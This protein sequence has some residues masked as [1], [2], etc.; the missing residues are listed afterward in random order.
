MPFVA[1][2]QQFAG[3]VGVHLGFSQA[4]KGE[5]RVDERIEDI[6]Q[7]P[8]PVGQ[9]GSGLAERIVLGV[10]GEC[11]VVLV[12]VQGGKEEGVKQADDQPPA[13]A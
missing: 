1:W 5:A 3:G 12:S 8:V 2:G 4:D 7:G 6:L 11:E 10:L 13:R 9:H